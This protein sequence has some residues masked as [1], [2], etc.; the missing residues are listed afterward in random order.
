VTVRLEDGCVVVAGACGVEEAETL[1]D[2]LQANPGVTVDL[3]RSTRLHTAL[4][5]ILYAVQP[6]LRGSPADAFAREWLLPAADG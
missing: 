2:L 5:Q 1:L 4:V 6:P 3:G